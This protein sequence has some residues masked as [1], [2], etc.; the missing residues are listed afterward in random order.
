MQPYFSI[1]NPLLQGI[2]FLIVG[3]VVFQT[4][5]S[6]KK[7]EQQHQQ[8]GQLSAAQV[9]LANREL[10]KDRAFLY[11]DPNLEESIYKRLMKEAEKPA[12]TAPTNDSP[13]E[14]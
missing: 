12:N 14:K 1:R 4:I 11:D 13:S 3:V 10:A 6:T 7:A 8:H 9:E 5:I 2:G